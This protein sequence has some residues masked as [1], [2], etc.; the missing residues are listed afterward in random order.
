MSLFRQQFKEPAIQGI[1]S[2][3]NDCDNDDFDL[4]TLALK[5]LAAVVDARNENIDPKLLAEI[6]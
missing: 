3:L 5:T 4:V 2:I 6:E 1:V